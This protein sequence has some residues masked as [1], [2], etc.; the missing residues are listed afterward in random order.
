MAAHIDRNEFRSAY[1]CTCIIHSWSKAGE[2]IRAGRPYVGT[3][4][5]HNTF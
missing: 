3:A 2:Y 1:T 4:Q 5:M